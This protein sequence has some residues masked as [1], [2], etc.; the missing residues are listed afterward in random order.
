MLLQH[1]FNKWKTCCTT[2]SSRD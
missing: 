1:P 2:Q